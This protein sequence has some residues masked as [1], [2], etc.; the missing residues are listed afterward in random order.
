[1]VEST[2]MVEGIGSVVDIASQARFG[3]DLVV[4][5]WTCSSHSVSDNGRYTRPD[6]YRKYTTTITH[7]LSSSH[8]SPGEIIRGKQSTKKMET[9]SIDISS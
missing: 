8:F 6:Q 9:K 7:Q 2:H 4:A 3:I 1:M 5:S